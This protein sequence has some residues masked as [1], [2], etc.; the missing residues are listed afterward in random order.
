[1]DNGY[2]FLE[3]IEILKNTTRRGWELHNVPNPESVSDHMY[4]M[5][6]M[7]LMIPTV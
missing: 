7:C 6:I 5:A 1:M 2:F 3:M 4:R